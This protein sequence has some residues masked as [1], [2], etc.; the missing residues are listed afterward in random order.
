MHRDRSTEEREERS[1]PYVPPAIE[2]SAKFETL[3]LSCG[4]VPGD[5]TPQCE[6]FNPTQS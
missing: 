4:K 6:V 1:T 3:A 5:G 2:E